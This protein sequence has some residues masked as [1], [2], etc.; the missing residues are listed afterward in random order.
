MSRLMTSADSRLAAISKVVRVRVLFSKNRLN[1]LLPRSSGTFLTS[2]SLTLRKVPAVSR[3]CVSTARGRPSIDSRWISSPFALSCG[4]RRVQHQAVLPSTLKLN[5][6]SSR[7]APA[8]SDCAGG[9]RR[10][11][12]GG[13]V[14]CDRQLAAAAVDQHGQLHAG[15]AAEVEQLVDHGA[16]RAAGVEHVVEQ[17]D[18]R[19]RRSSNGSW[20]ASV[21]R[22]QAARG[23]VV[24][25]QRAGDDAG[26]AAG[27]PRSACSRSASQAPPDQ[28]PTSTRVGR[29]AAAARR[30]S[31]SAVQRLGVGLQQVAAGSWQAPQELFEDQRGRAGVGIAGAVGERLGG[32]VALVDL[33]HRQLE[34]RRAAGARSARAR[35]VLSCSAPSGW[36]GTP[37]TS[38]SGCHSRTMRVDRRQARVALRP[39]WCAAA[40]R[41]AAAVADGDADAPRAEVEGQEAQRGRVAA[42]RTALCA[43]RVG[44]RVP[45]RP[46]A[47]MRA[48]R[49]ATASAGRCR[50]ATARARSAARS[51]CRR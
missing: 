11:A 1:T 15:R 12:C 33:V 21:P 3:I 51:A 35:R 41:G 44:M 43:T 31:S 18:V 16:D 22:G 45:G 14:G 50:A 40:S 13:E 37:T 23:E 39:R 28:M 38:A 36:N 17:Q 46:R 34:A 27:R 48:P 26:A 25:V 10:S 29:A 8:R 32:A 7:R 6:P 19:C 5:A 30:A 4:L 47:L 49:P 20:V 24:A 2:R 42:H 9:Q